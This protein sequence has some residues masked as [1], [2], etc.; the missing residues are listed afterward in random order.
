MAKQNP[1]QKLYDK[2]NLL[3]NM[4]RG[5]AFADARVAGVY[6]SEIQR[7]LG[8]EYPVLKRII[9]SGKTNPADVLDLQNIVEEYRK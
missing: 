5:P 4:A 2:I 6:A 8:R 7:D 1:H 3:V 9:S